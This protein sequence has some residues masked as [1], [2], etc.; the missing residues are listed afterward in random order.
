ML[1]SKPNAITE[2]QRNLIQEYYMNKGLQAELKR[3]AYRY[4]KNCHEVE[5]VVQE[6]FVRI[7]KAANVFEQIL[8]YKRRRYLC[9]VVRNVAINRYRRVK[10]DSILTDSSYWYDALPSEH[11]YAEIAVAKV[12]MAQIFLMITQLD[13]KYKA[14]L[15]LRYV[16]DLSHRDISNHLGI[17]ETLS[18]KRVQRAIALLN[19]KVG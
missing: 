10:R 14:P 7:M 12:A 5:D 8:E 15:L 4:L 2:N 13:S 3:I 6:A 16:K 9:V 17:A 1:E 11:D 19:E 18:R